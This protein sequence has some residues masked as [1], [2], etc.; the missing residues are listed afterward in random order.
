MGQKRGSLS[1]Q[2]PFCLN[3]SKKKKFQ[4]LLILLYSC[5]FFIYFK[6]LQRT[7]TVVFFFTSLVIGKLQTRLGR[8]IMSFVF[9]CWLYWKVYSGYGYRASANSWQYYKS[10][11]YHPLAYAE[12]LIQFP[13]M[14]EELVSFMEFGV[15]YIGPFSF[16]G[17]LFLFFGIFQ[18]KL[19]NFVTKEAEDK[20][21]QENPFSRL[22]FTSQS[23][24]ITPN[25]HGAVA[26]IKKKKQANSFARG[27]ISLDSMNVS[28]NDRN[29][30]HKNLGQSSVGYFDKSIIH[31]Y[32]ANAN[33]IMVTSAEEFQ[34]KIAESGSLNMDPRITD[35]D[36]EI[37]QTSAEFLIRDKTKYDELNYSHIFL[38]PRGF[39]AILDVVIC[40]QMYNYCDTILPDFLQETYGYEPY[41]IS[42]IYIAQNAAF[43]ST[44]FIAPKV[45]RRISLVLCVILGQMVQAA[46]CYLIGPSMFFNITPKIYL[47]IIGFLISGFASPFTLVPPYKELELCLSYHKNKR[48]D[49]EAVQDIVSGVFNTAYAMGGIVGPLFGYYTTYFT[50]FRTTSDIQGL[51]LLASSLIQFFLMYLPQRI[52]E[53]RLNNRLRDSSTLKQSN[54]NESLIK[55]KL[56]SLEYQNKQ[57][58]DLSET[59]SMLEDTKH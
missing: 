23:A 32:E 52:S 18:N 31:S 44:C 22:S 16:T 53:A 49:P 54:Q 26:L 14:Q 48:F 2:R 33:V 30:S 9:D 8:R 7:Y 37:P 39:F 57:Q 5:N 50:N 55:A 42:L 56:L 17:A 21:I 24:K 38:T 58:K 11:N 34:R 43:V 4:T 59:D 51:I 12:L 13:E 40:C 46:S 19:I 3:N 41:I 29:F 45:A 25:I 27:H 1:F 47:T 10:N 20:V 36:D 6:S 35:K 15:G 28:K